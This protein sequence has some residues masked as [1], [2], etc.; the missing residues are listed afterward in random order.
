MKCTGDWDVACMMDAAMC[1]AL[2]GRA[3]SEALLLTAISAKQD[4]VIAHCRRIG[5]GWC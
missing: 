3:H 2:I 4:A 5:R 1:C